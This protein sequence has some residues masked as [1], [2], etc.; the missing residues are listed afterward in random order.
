MS[1]VSYKKYPN[2]LQAKEIASLLS[3]YNIL[4]EYVENKNSLDSNFS[5]VLLEEYEIKIKPEDFKKADEIL[6]KQ[7]SQ[8]IDSLPDD[9]YLFSFSNKELIDIVIK[10]DEW[11]ELDY[12]L[13]IHLLKSR[14]VSVTN[15]SIEKANNQRI[16]ELKKPEKS[17]SAWIA[18]GYICAIL[19]GFLGY[20]IGYILLTQKKTLPNGERIYV[21]SES[22]RKHGKN[23]LYLGTSFFVLSIILVLT[24]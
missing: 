17:N 22:D 12:A 10:K 21:Y 14:G 3:K 19:G 20:V 24:L 18:V 11:S 4:N 23:I 5:S 13:A 8:L 1:F 15:E 7:A 2:S 6:F 9:Y 16:N